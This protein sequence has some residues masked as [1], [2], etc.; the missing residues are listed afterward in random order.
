VKTVH[1]LSQ[2]C[3]AGSV[4]VSEVVHH[5]LEDLYQFELTTSASNGQAGHQAWRLTGT[6]VPTA[7]EVLANP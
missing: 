1:A 5:R 2:V 7:S 6:T 4:L 3:P